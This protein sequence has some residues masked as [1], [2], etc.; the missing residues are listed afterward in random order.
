MDFVHDQLADGRT[1]RIFV[2]LDTCTRECLALVPQP[3]FR[4]DD[5]CRVLCDVVG[6]RGAPA[7]V[8]CDRGTEFTSLAVDH[9]AYFN[10][11]ALDFSRPATP[12]DNAVV[13]SFN[14]SL[15][16]ECLS[17]ALFT[18]PAEVEHVLEAW[19][20]DYNNVRPHTS[21]GHRSPAEYR[22]IISPPPAAT[23]AAK[24]EA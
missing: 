12:T 16:R 21:L 14:A 5:V 8:Q 3:R 7:V 6:Q 11:V 10:R 15:R 18:S 19:R 22:A 2:L 20:V 23:V 9:W 4:A 17:H 1:F 24:R 13:E